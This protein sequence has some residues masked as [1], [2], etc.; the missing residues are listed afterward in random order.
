MYNFFIKRYEDFITMRTFQKNTIYSFHFMLRSAST[1]GVHFRPFLL[2]FTWVK[3]LLIPKLAVTSDKIF[4]FQ[5]QV[6]KLEQYLEDHY[7]IN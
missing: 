2:N 3:H 5:Q 7:W 1:F 4:T 6:T